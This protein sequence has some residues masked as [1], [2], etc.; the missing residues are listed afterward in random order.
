MQRLWPSPV[1]PE[2]YLKNK[3]YLEVEPEALCPLCHTYCGLPYHAHYE[4]WVTGLLG[5]FLYIP[6]ARFLCKILKRTVSYLPDFALTYRWVN[7]N[8]VQSAF[9][10][11]TD[12]VDVRRNL[13][14]CL[15]YWRLF[16]AWVPSLLET[17]GS[18]LGRAPPQAQKLWPWLKKTCGSLTSAT[19][20]L[21][22]SWKITLFARYRC[23][24]SARS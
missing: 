22:T 16:E 6:V 20:E 11:Q 19:R 15:R 8:T 3:L 4:R 14:H 7:C 17:I 12:R 5:T 24:Q 10:G 13:D 21:V 1:S 23:H 18:G 2:E 9:D